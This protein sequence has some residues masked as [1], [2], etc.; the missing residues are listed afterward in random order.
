MR[1]YFSQFI[2]HSSVFAFSTLTASITLANEQ[3]PVSEKED[4]VT[5]Q[6][7]VVTG[8]RRAINSAL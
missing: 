5:L 4:V 8:S 1:T 3:R 2:L 6:S 7:V